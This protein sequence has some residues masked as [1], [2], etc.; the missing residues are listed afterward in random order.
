[1]KDVK[2]AYHDCSIY[3]DKGILE[4]MYSLTCSKPHT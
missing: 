2:H 3:G 1:M 4:L